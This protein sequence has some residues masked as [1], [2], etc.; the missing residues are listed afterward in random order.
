[1]GEPARNASSTAAGSRS[2][3]TTARSWSSILEWVDWTALSPETKGTLEQIGP[4]LAAGLNYR[5]IGMETGETPDR[6]RALVTQVKDDLVTH[7][8]ERA[9]GLVAGL[10][11]RLG[12][13]RS[14]TAPDAAGA[15]TPTLRTDGPAGTSPTGARPAKAA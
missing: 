15:S 4:F 5:E 12:Q 8:R 14:L 7:V 6:V 9:P 2:S 10:E 11:A 13:A 3:S 1:M